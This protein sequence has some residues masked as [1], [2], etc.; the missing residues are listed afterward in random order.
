MSSIVHVIPLT[1]P[2]FGEEE[3]E[4]VRAVLASG[5]VGLGPRTAEFE[6]RFGEYV[7]ARYCI[8]TNS[9]TAALHLSLLLLDL[10]SDDEVIVPAI[11]FVASAHAARHAGARVVFAD[12]DR[13]TLTVDPA[14]VE[15]KL[16]RKTRALVAVHYGGHPCAMDD[17]V[18]I[19]ETARITVVEDAAHA[20][21]AWYRQRRVGSIS[22]LTCFSFQATKN[23]TTGEGGAI[24]TNDAEF[25]ARLSRLRC[26][27]ID[28]DTWKRVG[29]ARHDWS[30]DVRELGFKYHMHDVAAAI[31]LVQLARLD[32][33]NEQRRRRAARYDS[34]FGSLD[35]LETP[36]V[37]SDVRT[38]A[39]N[40]VIHLD[41]RDQLHAWL[42]AHGIASSV[43]YEPIHHH[44][45]YRATEATV[46]V[47][48]A[49]WR[50][51]LLLP[52]YPELAPADQERIIDVVLAFGDRL[53]GIGAR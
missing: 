7:G 26:S 22:P 12:V 43:H 19:A 34:A 16:S 38:A 46:P 11:T 25:A 51:I 35:W 21:G 24:T 29:G 32:E 52:L 44:S 13:R 1:R 9:A 31:G 30:Y 6:R 14:D 48:E 36:V 42:A 8:A 15:R 28:R 39:H 47:A 23:M 33:R 20:A 5:W 2:D 3:V 17:L 45:A 37:R 53:P 40:Y 50:R 10:R 49:E 41:H 27:G 4:A 18:P